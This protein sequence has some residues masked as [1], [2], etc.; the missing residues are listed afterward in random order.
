MENVEQII[1]I[2]LIVVGVVAIARSAL[3]GGLSLAGLV[4]PIL[5]VVIGAF[6]L[7]SR[8]F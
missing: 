6:L 7:R 3:S 5:L 8:F 2:I 1:G 4:V